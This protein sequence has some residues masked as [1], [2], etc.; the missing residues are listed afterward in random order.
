MLR[1]IGAGQFR[2][3]ALISCVALAVTVSVTC[4][5]QH[6]KARPELRSDEGAWRK[7]VGVVRHLGT[8]VRTLPKAVKWVCYGVCSPA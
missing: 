6:E 2:K 4:W 5:T 3:L 8:S 1:W 7:I